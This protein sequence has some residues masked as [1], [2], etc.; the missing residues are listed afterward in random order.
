[1]RAALAALH[2]S[3]AAAS[4][5]FRATLTERLL[6]PAGPASLCGTSLHILRRRLPAVQRW[7]QRR[8]CR[9]ICSHS[10]TVVPD[11]TPCLASLQVEDATDYVSQQVGDAQRSIEETRAHAQQSLEQYQKVS[12]TEQRVQHLSLGQTHLHHQ[13]ACSHASGF[14]H[15]KGRPTHF[16]CSVW[17]SI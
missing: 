4:D 12:G 3:S 15:H 10:D 17:H 1:M 5:A 13:L 9:M 2:S 6:L 8:L 11:L 14:A 16:P 7:L